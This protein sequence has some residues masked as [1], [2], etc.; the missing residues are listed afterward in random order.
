MN[1]E[2][3]ARHK[4]ALS[5]KRSEKPKKMFT[6]TDKMWREI[7]AH[8]YNFN[9]DDIEVTALSEITQQD[10]LDFFDTYVGASAPQRRKLST[11]VISVVPNEDSEEEVA[12]DVKDSVD[13]GHE[14][15]N[16][17]QYKTRLGL[18]P[19]VQPFVDLTTLKRT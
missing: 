9:R 18:H 6:R 16:I 5:D 12:N 1:A 3:F 17:H 7:R 4:Q 19:L 8:R 14:V 13:C 10:L 2:E 11:H 15:S